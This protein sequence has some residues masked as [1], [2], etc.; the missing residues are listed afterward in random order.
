MERYT[1]F[2]RRD[3]PN[4]VAVCLELDIS[5]Q[6]A[7][8]EE[9]QRNM[10]EAIKEHLDAGRLDELDDQPRSITTNLLREFWLAKTTEMQ[11]ES[12]KAR[13]SNN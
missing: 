11:P 13:F 1:I 10:M 12:I 2:V 6:G 3:G 7:S 9:A 5:S 8:L 4:Y